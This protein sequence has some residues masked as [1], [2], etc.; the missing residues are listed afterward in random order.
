MYIAAIL[1]TG[2]AW[3][4]GLLIDANL[5]IGDP[6]G[7]ANFRMLFPLLVMGTFVLRSIDRK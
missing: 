5:D 7:F 2:A 1:S 6:M 4:V 3:F